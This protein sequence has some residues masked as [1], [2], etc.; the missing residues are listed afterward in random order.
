MK[1]KDKVTIVTGSA[2]EIGRATALL[3]GQEGGKLVIADID[4]KKGTEFDSLLK[5]IGIQSL[6]VKTDIR[7]SNEVQHMVNMT[8]DHFGKI[9]VLVNNAGVG[10]TVPIVDLAEEDWNNV[11]DTNLKSVYLCCKY[12]IPE[13]I[14]GGGGSIVNIASILGIVG[15]GGFAAYGV[16]KGGL[17]LLT[18]NI[19]IDY[20]PYNIRVNAVSPGY[21]ETD[22]LKR[23]L[24]ASEDP[25]KTYQ[26]WANLHPLGRIGRA[27]EIAHGILFLASD[28]SSFITGSNM[29]IDGGY[30]IQ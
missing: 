18:K 23:S 11:I 8:I 20:A 17:I 26:Q 7:Q 30:T 12:T 25:K 14:R 21:V 29:V 16:A 6:F 28:D 9:D 2:S 15:R 5:D 4:Y 10:L 3:F 22:I 1:V 27:E 19:A 13:M 24:E